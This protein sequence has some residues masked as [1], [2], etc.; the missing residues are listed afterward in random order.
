MLQMAFSQILTYCR[1]SFSK[2]YEIENFFG[3]ELDFEDKQFPIKIKDIHKTEKNNFIGISVFG[4]E[5]KEKYSPYV[6]K[7]TFKKHVSLLIS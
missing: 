2:N 6:S 7:N 4:Y 3:D 1:S 5:N